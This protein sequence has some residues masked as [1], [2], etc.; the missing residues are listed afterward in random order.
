MELLFK[1][2]LAMNMQD[3][4]KQ[5]IIIQAV[6]YRKMSTNHNSLSIKQLELLKS[7]INA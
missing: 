2:L 7:T 3:D 6:L 5:A 4:V 1:F